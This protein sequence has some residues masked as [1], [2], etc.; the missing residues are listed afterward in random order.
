V[1]KIV[2][3]LWFDQEAEEA[4]DFYLSLFPD[5]E[6]ERLYQALTYGGSVWMPLDKD[7]IGK[8]EEISFAI[9]FIESER[10]VRKINRPVCR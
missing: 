5:S 6:I 3:Q 10:S 2:T 7:P 9:R 8:Y 4:V 1:K